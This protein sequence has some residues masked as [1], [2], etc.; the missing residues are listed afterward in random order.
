MQFLKEWFNRRGS[1]HH[2]YIFF[3]D[4][5]ENKNFLKEFLR[6]SLSFKIDGNPDYWQEDF[7]TFGIEDSRRIISLASRKSLNRERMIIVLSFNLCTIEAQNALLKL[8]EEPAPHVHFF[9]FAPRELFVVPTLLSR[10]I[11]APQISL[12]KNLDLTSA[13]NFLNL[14]L[15]DRLTF[16]N[17]LSEAGDKR[18]VSLFFDALEEVLYKRFIDTREPWHGALQNILTVREYLFDRSSSLK[19]LLEHCANTLPIES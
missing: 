8:F 4:I 6:E 12:E 2:A 13:E 1:L 5:A 11:V 14:S 18:A 10:M 7:D 16:V 15:K 17:S 19:I 3:G 9:I